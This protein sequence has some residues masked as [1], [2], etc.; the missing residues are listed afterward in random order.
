MP[1]FVLLWSDVVVLLSVLLLALYV[2]RVRR[3]VNLRATWHKVMRDR[4]RKSVV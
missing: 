1:K 2:L 3:S 4:D